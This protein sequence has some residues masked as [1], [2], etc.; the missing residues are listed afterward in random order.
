MNQLFL[1]KI[2][3]D[4]LDYHIVANIN[5]SN[6]LIGHQILILALKDDRHL[7]KQPAFGGVVAAD[8]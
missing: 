6:C 4:T 2:F 7:G 1:L 8:I 5:T 3:H